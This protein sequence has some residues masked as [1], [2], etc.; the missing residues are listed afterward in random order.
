MIPSSTISLKYI[1]SKNTADPRY[2]IKKVKNAYIMK[3]GRYEQRPMPDWPEISCKEK[4]RL[5]KHH[6]RYHHEEAPI[7]RNVFIKIFS[8]IDNTF[9][10][11][12]MNL[13]G[14]PTSIRMRKCLE[15][16]KRF[17]VANYAN[18]GKQW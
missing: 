3:P 12:E 14:V 7:Y 5:H 17:N 15:N 1:K 2:Y 4:I 16:K 10:V 13:L 9:G 6:K 18:D 8:G 11:G